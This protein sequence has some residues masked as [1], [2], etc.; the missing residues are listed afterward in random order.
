[1][2]LLDRR[3]LRYTNPSGAAAGTKAPLRFF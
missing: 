1:V 2:Q 3:M